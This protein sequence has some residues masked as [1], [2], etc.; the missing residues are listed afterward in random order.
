VLDCTCTPSLGG[1]RLGHTPMRMHSMLA[2]PSRAST[3]GSHALPCSAHEVVGMH[4]CKRTVFTVPPTCSS[5]TFTLPSSSLPPLLAACE[6]EAA[7]DPPRCRAI[8]LTGASC[9][10]H[11]AP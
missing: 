6:E 4:A 10:A 11:T 5:T 7:A 3:H 9:V 2:V 1:A 8:H